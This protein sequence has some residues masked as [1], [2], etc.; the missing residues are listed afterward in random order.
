MYP[1]ILSQVFAELRQG[2]TRRPHALSTVQEGVHYSSRRVIRG[3]EKLLRGETTLCQKA[4]A[5]QETQQIPCDVCSSDEAS[6]SET[7][8]PASMYCVQCQQNYCEQCS[9]CHRKIKSCS[10]HRQFDIGSKPAEI[11]KLLVNVCEEHKGKEI[12]VFC[13]YC[14]IAVCMMCVVISH[15]THHWTDVDKVSDD[16]RKMVLS[17][18]HKVSEVWKNTKDVHQRL[19]KEK[20]DVIAHLA[21]IEDEINT[22]A[23]KLIVAIQRD[24]VKLLSEVKS[25]KLKRVRQVETLKQELEQ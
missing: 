24:K 15:K 4:L 2:Q 20:N 19:E 12:K 3:A 23:D 18:T 14:K 16:F 7:V 8:K 22:A 17:D 25:I 6:T 1:H 21:G 5:G 10:S 11:L 9:L 13:Q